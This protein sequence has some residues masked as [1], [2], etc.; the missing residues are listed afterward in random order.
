MEDNYYKSDYTGKEIDE[1]IGRI[2]HGD[3]DRLAER[4]ETAATKAESVS[5]KTPY[6]N[7]TNKNWMVVDTETGNYRDSG[8]SSKGDKGDTGPKG[9]P[10]G[11]VNL[12]PGIVGFYINNNGHLIMSVDDGA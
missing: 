7:A 8:Y 10:G 3:I 9:D 2:V 11:M 1:S 6:I 5:V 4:A 12:G